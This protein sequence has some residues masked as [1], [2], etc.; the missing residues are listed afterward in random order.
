METYRKIRQVPTVEYDFTRVIVKVWPWFVL[1]LAYLTRVI[2][3]GS[4]LLRPTVEAQR[5]DESVLWEFCLRNEYPL[6]GCFCG[7]HIWLRPHEFR[8]RVARIRGTDVLV[9]HQYSRDDPGCGYYRE[10]CIP[11]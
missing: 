8:A 6:P 7:I 5:V 11:S 1:F 3:N 10:L 2:L 4:I 9:C